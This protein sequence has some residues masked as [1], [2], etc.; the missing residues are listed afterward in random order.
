M[1]A[2]TTDKNHVLGVR[3][4]SRK[5]AKNTKTATEEKLKCSQVQVFISYK[6]QVSGLLLTVDRRQWTFPNYQFL[7]PQKMD[8]RP[9]TVEPQ[10]PPLGD[11]GNKLR[12]YNR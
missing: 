5:E 2:I 6:L 8:Y 4:F 12:N 1:I 11:R 7:I 3:A 9:W 10:I